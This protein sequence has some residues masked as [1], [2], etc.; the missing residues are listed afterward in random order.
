M[1]TSFILIKSCPNLEEFSIQRCT[2]VERAL[3]ASFE[4]MKNLRSFQYLEI[5]RSLFIP[6]EFVKLIPEKLLP[7]LE[8]MIIYVRTKQENE[9]NLNQSFFYLFVIDEEKFH[10]VASLSVCRFRLKPDEIIEGFKF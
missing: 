6:F 4:Y 2:A 1:N 9:V 5:A 7:K 8:N 3:V 10:I